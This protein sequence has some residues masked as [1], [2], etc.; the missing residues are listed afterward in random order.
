MPDEVWQNK[1]IVDMQD[2]LNTLKSIL[3]SK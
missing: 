3:E 1:A 2:E